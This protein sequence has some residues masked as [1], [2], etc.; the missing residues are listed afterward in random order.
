VLV[1]TARSNGSMGPFSGGAIGWSRLARPLRINH[2]ETLVLTFDCDGYFKDTLIRMEKER[3][4]DWW[5]SITAFA[6][7]MQTEEDR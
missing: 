5:C 1:G 7:G 2:N 3:P 6:L 4:K